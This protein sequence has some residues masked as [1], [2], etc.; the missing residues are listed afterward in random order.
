M[1]RLPDRGR[2]NRD[3]ELTFTFDGRQYRGFAG[4]TLASA[5]L[6]NGVQQI[7]TSI[8]F[9]R[10]RGVMAAGVEDANALVQLEAPFPEPML[11]ATTVELYHGLIARGLSGQGKLASEPD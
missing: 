1:T 9:G 11:T 4:D 5:L 2:I 6:A 8:K 3:A 7:G 10:P